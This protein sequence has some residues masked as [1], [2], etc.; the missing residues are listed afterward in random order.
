MSPLMVD[1]PVFVMVLPASTAY[2]DAV[3]RSTVPVAAVAYWVLTA[4]NVRN[5]IPVT[6]IVLKESRSDRNTAG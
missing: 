1:V 4:A 2:D 3:P 6:S 5:A